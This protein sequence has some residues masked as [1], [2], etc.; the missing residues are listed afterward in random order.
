LKETSGINLWH[1]TENV[2]AVQRTPV[3]NI[4]II[5][6]IIIIAVVVVV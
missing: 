3:T 6:I 2:G 5:I 1:I 4:I